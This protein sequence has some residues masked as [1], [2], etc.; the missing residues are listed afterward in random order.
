MHIC[1]KN[2]KKHTGNTFPTKIVL[3]LKYKIKETYETRHIEWHEIYK[4]ECRLDA[5]VCNNKNVGMK[6]NA[7]VNA[8]N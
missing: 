6:I 7:G 5:N 4:C 8:K 2:C 1:Y 3:I